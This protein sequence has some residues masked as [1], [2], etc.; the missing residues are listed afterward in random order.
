YARKGCSVSDRNILL[1]QRSSPAVAA[2]AAPRPLL[3]GGFLVLLVL[4]PFAGAY[5]AWVMSHVLLLA[6]FAAG[7]NLLLGYT[8]LLSFGHAALFAVGAYTS[9]FVL[10]DY[11]SLPLAVLA[12]GAAAALAS[13]VIGWL[14]IRHTRIY[15]SMLTLA[16]GMMVYSILF[17]WRSVTGGDDGIVG[18][19]RGVLGIPGAGL[20]LASLGLFYYA[21]L[22]VVVVEIGR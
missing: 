15:F 11:P 17:K 18:V 21:V 5:P 14:S 22:V 9:A 10:R 8:G 1:K 13:V 2:K 7:Y 20:E 19:P 6:L 12:G 16:F 3:I 4:V